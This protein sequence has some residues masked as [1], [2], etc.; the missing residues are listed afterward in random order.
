MTFTHSLQY[1]HK[2]MSLEYATKVHASSQFSCLSWKS[3]SSSK[4][5]KTSSG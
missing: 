2:T 1:K 3:N 4:L 5:M